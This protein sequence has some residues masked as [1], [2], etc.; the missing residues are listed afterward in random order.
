ME[1]VPEPDNVDG[2][3]KSNIDELAID[4]EANKKI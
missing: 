3:A 2:R 1:E 4:S